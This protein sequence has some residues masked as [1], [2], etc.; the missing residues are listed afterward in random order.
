MKSMYRRLSNLSL[1][2]TGLFFLLCLSGPGCLFAQPDEVE[3]TLDLSS[4]ATPTPKL[5]RPNIDLSGMGYS[6][7]LSWPQNLSNPEVIDT[8]QKEVGFSGIYRLQYN[9]WEINELARNRQLQ[10]EL[11]NNY[12]NIIKKISDSGGIVLL[13]IFGT[14]AGLGKVLDKRS[15]PW[16]L[17][18]FKELIKGYI[19]DLSCVKKYNVWYE[20]WST[21]DLDDFFLGRKQ[22]YFNL[23][24]V[25]AESVKELENE[26]KIKIPVG[27]PSVS[28]WFQNLTGNDITTPEQS[29]IY[30]LIRFCSRYRLPLDFISWHSYTTDPQIEK[31]LT[32]Y[33]KNSVALIRAWL[34]YFNLSK[35]TA[36]IVD[37]WNYDSGANMLAERYQR[38]NVTAA[39]ILARLRNMYEAG[40]DYQLYF[41]LED[42]QNNK[43]GINRNVGVFW[44][45]PN[46]GKYKG[47]PKQGLYGIFKALSVLGG[48]FFS[49]LK[50][51]DEFVGVIAT[52]SGD[53]CTILLYN[54][55]DTS[56]ALDYL[57]RNIASLKASERRSLLG[58]VNSE[59]IY[60]VLR[61]ELDITKLRLSARLKVLLKKATELNE[62]AARFTS[63]TR[64]VNLTLKNLKSDYSYQRYVI[65]SASA[66]IA[67]S[68]PVEEK[69]VTQGAVYKE[70]LSLEPYSVSVIT[71]KLRPKPPEPAAAPVPE[72]NVTMQI[73]NA[74][75]QQA[76]V[77]MPPQNLTSN[78]EK[79]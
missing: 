67:E 7:Q 54:Y 2:T 32:A 22:E 41:C 53:S 36:L 44:F 79:K 6:R 18:A 38:N 31:E 15:P 26:Y 69:D 62:K 34:S 55:I 66:M 13:D 10:Q 72:Q 42:F 49:S 78:L 14:P 50:T 25:V 71:L 12:E 43:E 33:G 47:G 4:A 11:L 60:A 73:S 30:E 59:K 64:S 28:W 48:E 39:F 56:L 19:R 24:R 74:T 40:L 65:N 37:E 5:F 46:S 3:L 61:K 23:Y 16:D 45:E 17:R 8:W 70:T 77:T 75:A 51:N 52:R 68:A 21:P 57:S 20:V 1:L 58:L 76:A 63:A 35:N 27:G 29:L 9:L